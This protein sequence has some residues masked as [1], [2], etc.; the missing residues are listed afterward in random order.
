[1]KLVI[2]FL[3]ACGSIILPSYVDAG[4]PD[5]LMARR[6]AAGGYEAGEL[7]EWGLVLRQQINTDALRR[8]M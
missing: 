3:L 7:V 6:M 4:R 8:E 1:M 2:H 5:P